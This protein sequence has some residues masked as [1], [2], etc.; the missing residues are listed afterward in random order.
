MACFLGITVTEE[1]RA[2]VYSKYSRSLTKMRSAERDFKSCDI[3]DLLRGI[4]K[5]KKAIYEDHETRVDQLNQL[6]IA[7][8]HVTLGD[9][10][11]LSDAMLLRLFYTIDAGEIAASAITANSLVLTKT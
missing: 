11:Y 3:L 4:R 10:I 1:F 9:K 6:M 7:V 2:L 8:S 5:R